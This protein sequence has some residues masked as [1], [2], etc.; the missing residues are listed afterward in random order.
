[1]VTCTLISHGIRFPSVSRPRPRPEAEVDGLPHLTLLFHES[2]NQHLHVYMHDTRHFII[3]SG[4]SGVFRFRLFPAIFW[5]FFGRHQMGL[6]ILGDFHLNVM[7]VG[8]TSPL[9][10]TF[11]LQKVVAWRFSQI[12]GDFFLSHF[13]SP[14]NL[15]SFDVSCNSVAWPCQKLESKDQNGQL[16]CAAAVHGPSRVQFYDACCHHHPSGLCYCTTPQKK[17]SIFWHVCPRDMLF[18]SILVRIKREKKCAEK[19][20]PKI[21][22]KRQATTFCKGKGSGQG[23]VH[24]TDS[25]LT[26][27]SPR[28]TSPIWCSPKNRQKIAGKSRNRKTPLLPD[29]MMKCLVSCIYTC[30]C[31]LIDSWK[32]RVRW[33]RPSTSASGLG[34]GLETE[35][36]IPQK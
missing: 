18:T 34:R 15:K 32:R 31:W 17:L 10:D 9:P 26:W 8:P 24:L 11:P 27:K 5:R 21:G 23:L 2:I 14:F 33:G 30:K 16:L 28:M 7:S 19:K 29:L 25:S 1:M 36:K 3:R 35:G 12:F 13:F 20:W 4:K 22:E 6:V